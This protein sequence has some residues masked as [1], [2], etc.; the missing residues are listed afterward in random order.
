MGVSNN[1]SEYYKTISNAD[2]LSILETP[3]DFQLAAIE[4]AKKE[5]SG[6][7]LSD[8]EIK[9]ARQVLFEKQIQKI[10]QREKVKA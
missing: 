1:F 7:H 5:L 9:E 2:L 3:G 8:E 4:A 10:K 6:R